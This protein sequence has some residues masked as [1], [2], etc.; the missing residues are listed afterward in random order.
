MCMYSTF[1]IAI[2]DLITYICKSHSQLVQKNKA[3]TKTK[4]RRLSRIHSVLIRQKS[5]GN[6]GK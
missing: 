3:N 4:K 2:N 5:N 1:K 6:K